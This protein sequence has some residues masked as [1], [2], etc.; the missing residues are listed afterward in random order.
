MDN[1]YNTSLAA[2]AQ[3]KFCKDHNLPVFSPEGDGRCCHCGKNIYKAITHL[4]GYTTGITVE[5][6]SKALITGCPHCNY[7]FVD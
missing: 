4:S 2:L 5:Q 3:R 6:A 7:S 1:D